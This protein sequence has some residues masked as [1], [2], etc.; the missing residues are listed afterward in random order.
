MPALI[1]AVLLGLFAG[2]ATVVGGVIG[3][4]F[5]KPSDKVL[6]VLFG[7]TAGTMLTA[8]FVR[9]IPG[10]LNVNMPAAL[11]GLVLGM[12]CLMIIDIKLP[13]VHVGETDSQ[14]LVR[15]GTLITVGDFIHDLPEGLAIGAGYMVTPPL[16]FLAMFAVF[17]HNAPEGVSDAVPLLA[18]GVRRSTTILATLIVSLATALGAFLGGVIGYISPGL[19]V[20]TLGF[21][22]GAVLYITSDELI[23]EAQRRGHGHAASAGLTLG[24]ILILIASQIIV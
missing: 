8:T 10:A 9:I 15:I 14:R 11:V 19:L 5:K 6:S 22:A 2:L 17:L 21:A 20:G 18:G 7:F 3:T 16:G 12:A 4:S 23:P 24:T 13:H 1:E